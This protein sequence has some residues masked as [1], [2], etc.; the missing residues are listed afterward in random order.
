MSSRPFPL[1]G[2]WPPVSSVLRSLSSGFWP[3]APAVA[4]GSSA[5]LPGSLLARS[6]GSLLIIEVRQRHARQALA[7]LAFDADHQTLL[8]RANQYPSVAFTLMASGAANAV[9]V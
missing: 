4:A 9:D 7:H 8:R 6:A 3:L 1:S 5:A 2:V